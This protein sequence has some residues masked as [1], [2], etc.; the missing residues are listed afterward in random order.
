MA[1]N[2]M[3]LGQVTVDDSEREFFVWI[4]PNYVIT[5]NNIAFEGGFAGGPSR[6][7][8][9]V[10]DNLMFVAN[11]SA[12]QI[13]FTP[14]HLN[15]IQNYQ[16]EYNLELLRHEEFAEF[17]SRLYALFLFD[18]RAEAEKYAE[19]HPN[20]TENRLLKRGLSVGRYKLSAHDGAWVDFLRLPRL[21][22]TETFTS[23]ARAYWS[24]ER[25][26][27]VE[28]SAFGKPWKGTS[29]REVVFYGRL[30]FPNRDPF[31]AD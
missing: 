5:R 1:T 17:P 21:L 30:N 24:G 9:D 25:A 10:P 2:S 8:D 22:D 26:D 7:G 4:N 3:K 27:A 14:F 18:D 20:Q 31:T 13:G 15:V 16:V 11:P 19:S 29:F 28:L 6:E 23:C 12:V